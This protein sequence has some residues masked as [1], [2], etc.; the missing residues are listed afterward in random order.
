MFEDAHRLVH[1][2]FDQ[3]LLEPQITHGKSW[4]NFTKLGCLDKIPLPP[5]N[6]EVARQMRVAAVLR[7]LAETACEYIYQ[8]VYLTEDGTEMGEVISQASPS[9]AQW[10]RRVLLNIEAKRQGDHGKRRAENAANEVVEMLGFFLINSPAETSDFKAAVK[11]WYQ[12]ACKVWMSLQQLEIRFEA[13]LE[14]QIGDQSPLRWKPLPDLL[15]KDSSPTEGAPN[16]SKTRSDAKDLV[17]GDIAAE[18]W[19]EFLA[20]KR[21][22]LIPVLPGYVLLEA[23]A[24]VARQELE[25]VTLNRASGIRRAAH[26]RQRPVQTV[27]GGANGST[28]DLSFLSQRG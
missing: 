5:S 25:A 14:V 3:L 18:V 20:T 4:Q 6:S 26:G 9:D 7:V 11:E 22:R 10:M 28:E 15:H 19:P 13:G 17:M 24:A 8:P 21:E 2:F 27:M 1:H 16:G 12:K 23:Q